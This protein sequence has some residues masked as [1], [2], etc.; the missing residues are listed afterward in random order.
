M[1]ASAPERRHNVSARWHCRISVPSLAKPPFGVV[2][3][4][5]RPVSA[6]TRCSRARESEQR[7]AGLRAS[8][9]AAASSCC[10]S[11]RWC[12][13]AASALRIAASPGRAAS[14]A[15]SLRA[16]CRRARRLG[17]GAPAGVGPREAT[18]ASSGFSGWRGSLA[19]RWGF[20]AEIRAA[21]S[22]SCSGA[23]CPRRCEAAG[24]CNVALR[25]GLF[26]ALGLASRDAGAT[27]WPSPT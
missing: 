27:R 20:A 24:S 1:T 21:R 11:E 15:A 2:G 18:R 14:V 26:S 5:T 13:S 12:R 17:L 6:H 9:S 10:R 25:S 3:L 22:G 19:G 16:A 23:L 4:H 8:A 7:V